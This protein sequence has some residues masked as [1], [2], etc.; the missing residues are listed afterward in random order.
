M[1]ERAGLGIGDKLPPEIEIARKLNVGRSKVREALIAWQN[2]GI[3]T[4]NKKAGTRLAVEVSTKSIHLPV[5]LVLEAESLLRTHAVRRPLEIEVVRLAARQADAQQRRALIARA[6]ELMAVFD[7]GEDW[8]PADY[9]FHRAIYA[10]SGNPLF[11][12][13]I[14]QIQ[15]AFH[16]IYQAPFDQ[17][18][19][20]LATIPLHPGLAQA[21]ADGNADQAAKIMTQIMDMVEAEVLSFMEGQND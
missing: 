14:R 15:D 10:A 21:I 20:G 12:Q 9:R 6:A 16:A 7:S 18:H 2:M 5:T 4:R 11:E 13:L 1:I 17:P 8:R 3:V 19:L